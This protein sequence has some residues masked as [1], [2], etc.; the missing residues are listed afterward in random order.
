[1]HLSG[2]AK[3]PPNDR[4]HGKIRLANSLFQG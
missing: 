3:S 4:Y 1:L 2:L